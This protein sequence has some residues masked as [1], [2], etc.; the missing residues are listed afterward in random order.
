[1]EILKYIRENFKNRTKE[2]EQLQYF[3]ESKIE[4]T[5]KIH[6]RIKQEEKSNRR[7]LIFITTLGI[8]NVFI[9]VFSHNIAI[10]I[11]SVAII[12][13]ITLYRMNK[14]MK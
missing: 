9:Q 14:G 11:S 10:K 12:V 5:R 13:G 7:Y 3:I 4:E 2:E 1:L 6:E 8:I